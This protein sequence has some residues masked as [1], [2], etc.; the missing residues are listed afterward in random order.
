MF[1]KSL[2]EETH[3]YLPTLTPLTTSSSGERRDWG[4]WESAV[5]I[6]AEGT[7]TGGWPGAAMGGSAGAH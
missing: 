2:A 4:E 6:V 7:A 3:L 1:G 5:L